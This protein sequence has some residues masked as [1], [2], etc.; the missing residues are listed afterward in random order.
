MLSS[1]SCVW[2][3][4]VAERG[5][6]GVLLLGGFRLLRCVEETLLIGCHLAG[7][8]ESLEE[9]LLARLALSWW[10]RFLHQHI[11]LGATGA[12]LKGE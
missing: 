8:A 7:T 6:Q 2:A 3:T 1:A 10:R 12:R 5:A 9:G 4:S 11:H